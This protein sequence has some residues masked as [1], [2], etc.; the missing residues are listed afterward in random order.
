MCEADA[1][2]IC[3]SYVLAY[4]VNVCSNVAWM[5]YCLT[6]K[7]AAHGPTLSATCAKLGLNIECESLAF[8]RNLWVTSEFVIFTYL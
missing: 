6:L 3:D 2:S 5:K 4:N 7:P 1:R 8:H